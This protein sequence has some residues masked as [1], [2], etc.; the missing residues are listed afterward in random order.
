MKLKTVIKFHHLTLSFIA[1][2]SF[3][4]RMS[5]AKVSYVFSLVMSETAG[6]V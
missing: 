4:C 2:D 6:G 1:V 3:I 5:A